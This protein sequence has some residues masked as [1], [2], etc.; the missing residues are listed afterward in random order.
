[1]KTL[2]RDVLLPAST[3][4]ALVIGLSIAPAPAGHAGDLAPAT[5]AAIAV[6]AVPVAAAVTP[7]AALSPESSPAEAKDDK[8]SGDGR[9]CR[10]VERIGKFRMTRCD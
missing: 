5:P 7:A 9:R 4:V 3:S 10:R 2:I 6:V 1:M 8:A